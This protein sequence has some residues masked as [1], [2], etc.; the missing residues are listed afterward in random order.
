MRVDLEHRHAHGA[1][2]RVGSKVPRTRDKILKELDRDDMRCVLHVK[3]NVT[4]KDSQSSILVF[5]E[6]SM[7]V[8]TFPST[9][10]NGAGVVDEGGDR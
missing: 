4:G 9:A 3:C 6:P 5:V 2:P 10:W 1:A 7:V 8:V